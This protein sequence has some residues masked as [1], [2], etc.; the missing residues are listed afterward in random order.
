MSLN[1]LI[2]VDAIA[3]SSCIL[4]C[5]ENTFGNNNFNSVLYL[6]TT[7]GS[8]R[9]F[10]MFDS[11]EYYHIQAPTSGMSDLCPIDP[12]RALFCYVCHE[13][14]TFQEYLDVAKNL[15]KV[16]LDNNNFHEIRLSTKQDFDKIFSYDPDL[17]FYSGHGTEEGNWVLEDGTEITKTDFRSSNKPLSVYSTCCFSHIWNEYGDIQYFGSSNNLLPFSDGYN[18]LS[19]RMQNI[20]SSRVGELCREFGVP[21]G[22]SDQASHSNLIIYFE[23]KFEESLTKLISHRN[24]NHHSIDRSSKI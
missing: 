4:I 13:S 21:E 2:I 24:K 15:F 20:P 14:E 22:I 3:Y 12:P 11:A 8:V 23:K 10:V 1:W 6:H 19:H 16:F 7:S 18:F 17:I 9:S 5:V